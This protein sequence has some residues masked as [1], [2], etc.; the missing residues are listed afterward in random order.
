MEE[1]PQMS[2]Q[3]I[4]YQALADD[5]AR[6]RRVHPGV[7]QHLLDAARREEAY[8]LLEVGCGTGNYLEALSGAGGLRVTGI[9]P[10]SAMLAQLHERLPD[11]TAT[12][13]RAEE[14]PI[15]A[16]SLDLVYS[17]DVIHHVGDRDAYF[18]EAARVLRPG[19]WICTVTD[20][21]ED[22]AARVPLSSH[23]PETVSYEL[24]RYPSVP[25]LRTEMKQAGFTALREEHVD[26]R[27]PLTDSTAY[28]NKAY[29]SLH[30]ISDSEHA[31]GI[32]RM[33]RDLVNGPIDARS[34]YTLLWGRK[35]SGVAMNTGP[36]L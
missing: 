3:G 8:D 2:P 14:L 15:P 29:S 4:N 28:R 32:E 9:D 6:Y 27:Y 17:V 1:N 16:A 31:R 7:L 11:A 30:L 33:E 19:G 22:I 25:T 12:L 23:F 10:S 26:L 13:G 24:R 36:G 34:L 18:A 5:Y 21:A 20:S 35:A